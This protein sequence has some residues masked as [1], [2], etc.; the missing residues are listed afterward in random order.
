MDEV[1]AP[2]GVGAAGALHGTLQGGALATTFTAS[3]GQVL[4]VAG[5]LTAAVLRDDLLARSS[6]CCRSLPPC[7]VRVGTVASDLTG[8]GTHLR[9]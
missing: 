1:S 7:D 9:L 6:R 5:E 8:G 2:G 3:H 4:M